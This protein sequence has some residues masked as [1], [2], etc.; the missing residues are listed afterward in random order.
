[1]EDL[2]YILIVVL[3][4]FLALYAIFYGWD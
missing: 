4:F 2:G 3:F 1:M